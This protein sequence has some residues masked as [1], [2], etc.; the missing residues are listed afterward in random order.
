MDKAKRKELIEQYNLIK[1]YMGV[2]Q[3]KNNKNG[4]I[5]LVTYPNLKNRWLT[6]TMQLNEGKHPNAGLQKEWKE[7]GQEAFCYEILEQK[8]ASEIK[9]MK[10][11]RKQLLKKW[12][13]LLQP[14]EDKGYNKQM[15]D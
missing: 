11:E 13:T 9:D 2:V 12:L 1:I 14:Y 10:W 8:D 7:F 5:F 15:E 4:K 3:I 6:I